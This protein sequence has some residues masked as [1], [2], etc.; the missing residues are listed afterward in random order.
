MKTLKAQ[1]IQLRRWTYGASDIAFIM[2]KGF[3]KKNK[4]RRSDLIPKVL[5]LLEGHVHWAVGAIL[6]ASAAFIPALLNPES[7]V[8]NILPVTVSRIQTIGLIGVFVSLFVCLKTL[9]PRPLRYKRHRTIFMVLQ[10]LYLPITNIVYASFAA[11]YSQ[12]RLMFGKYLTKFDVTVKV[13]KK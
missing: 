13:V 7:Y 5:R 6:L 9:P 8:A 10:W 12:T 4:V 2:E 11:L 3:F 1:F